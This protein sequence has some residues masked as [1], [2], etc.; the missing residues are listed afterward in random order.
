RTR[1]RLASTDPR[2]LEQLVEE[3]A[4]AV[5]RNQRASSFGKI[6]SAVEEQRLKD[7]VLEWLAIEKQRKQPF[8]V[9]TVEEERYFELGGLRL[10][11]RLDRID[12]LP[13]GQL[14][15]IDYKSG[16]QKRKKLE[17]ERPEEPQLLV[18]AAGIGNQV[19][20]ILFAQLKSRDVRAVGFTRDK[21]FVSR[22]VDVEGSRWEHFL[23]EGI[24]KV[25]LLATEF[26]SGRAAVAP[27]PHACE[28]CA[29]K[30]LCRIREQ[31][32]IGEE[33]EE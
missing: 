23:D 1:D 2:A 27:L 9:E 5:V 7:V 22:T 24:A 33:T 8:T 11:L 32:A 3:A 15:L 30:P 19:D 4:A 17:G 29:Q 26:K 10:R 6:V 25:E 13:N 16:E 20:G 21:H 14:L 31:L 12:R 28:F 18:Y